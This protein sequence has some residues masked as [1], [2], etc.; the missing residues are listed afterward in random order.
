MGHFTLNDLKRTLAV[1]QSG[2]R[3]SEVTSKN[4]ELAPPD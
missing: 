2:S 4:L 3:L 1:N